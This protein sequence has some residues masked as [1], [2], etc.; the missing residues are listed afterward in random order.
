MEVGSWAGHHSLIN[1]GEKKSGTPFIDDSEHDDEQRN[2]GVA[3]CVLLVK[4]TPN[5]TNWVVS[6]YA[7]DIVD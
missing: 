5:G 6:G 2:T 3:D 4:D 7:E 1:E